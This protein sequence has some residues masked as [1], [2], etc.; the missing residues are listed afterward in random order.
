MSLGDL[1]R[2]IV[3]NSQKPVNLVI[4][5][6]PIILKIYE[7][8]DSQLQS[9]IIKKIYTKKINDI[10]LI[11]K[12]KKIHKILNFEEFFSNIN[13]CNLSVIGAGH[14]GLPLS[15]FLLEKIQ[16]VTLYDKNIK[17][18]NDIKKNNLSFYERGLP[19]LLK[20]V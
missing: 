13:Y 20:K 14:I 12:K 9:N 18:L 19:S 15:I 2:N 6:K 3:S 11:S 7:N 16:N 17:V 8:F 10:I 1:R 4:N 5:K